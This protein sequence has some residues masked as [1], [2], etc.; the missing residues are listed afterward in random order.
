MHT[1]GALRCQIG[2]QG[3]PT[4]KDIALEREQTPIVFSCAKSQELT[5]EFDVTQRDLTGDR[6]TPP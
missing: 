6:H 4:P 3:Q 2:W 1:S 5:P